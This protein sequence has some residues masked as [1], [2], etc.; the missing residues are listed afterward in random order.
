MK[1]KQGEAAQRRRQL[2]DLTNRA[3]KAEAAAAR[4][5]VDLTDAR[6]VID[7]Q[8]TGHAAEVKALV[9]D[10]DAA[11]A[12]VVRALEGEVASLRAALTEA[13]AEIK[14]LQR[15]WEK[16]V[17]RVADRYVANGAPVES[18]IVAAGQEL[19]LLEHSESVAVVMDAEFNKNG[20]LSEE[21]AQR[22]RRARAASTRGY[23]F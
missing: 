10:R 12:P 8:K 21:G 15:R 9:A 6:A 22:I 18:A 2:E 7:S 4:L 23:G 17:A 3:E 13:Q 20:K 19:G 1:G 11:T 14:T 16:H 5:A